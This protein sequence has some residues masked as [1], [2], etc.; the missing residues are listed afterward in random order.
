M[1]NKRQKVEMHDCA[2]LIH[3]ELG[4]YVIPDIVN[5]ILDFGRIH[6][7]TV[8]LEEEDF[9]IIVDFPCSI[10]CLTYSTA[11]I[12]LKVKDVI[13]VDWD[14][15]QEIRSRTVLTGPSR[16]QRLEILFGGAAGNT[17]IFSKSHKYLIETQ[18]KKITF[19]E[20]AMKDMF[21]FVLDH[22]PFCKPM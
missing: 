12:Y 5:V 11:R 20:T 6:G 8:K 22:L 19:Y 17:T 14:P 18:D 10:D 2:K 16:I 7:T 4:K 3:A 21:N 15:L 13:T 9:E 1:S